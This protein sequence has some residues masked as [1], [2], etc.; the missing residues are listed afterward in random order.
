[1]KLLIFGGKGMAGHMLTQF[2][3][4][5]NNYDVNYTSRDK[6]DLESYYLDVRNFEKLVDIFK[7]LKPDIVINAVGLLN[8]QASQDKMT[9]IQ[10]NSLLPHQLDN[11]AKKNG[12]KII[13]ISTDCVFSGNCGDYKENDLPDGISDYAK[14]KALGEVFSDQHLTIRTSI[15]GPELKSNGIGLF[16]WFM[17][18]KGQIKGYKSVY[19]NG[20][21]TLE[22][23]KAIEQLIEQKITGLYHLGS[24]TK[25]SKYELLK[26]IQEV[27][28]KRD[29]TIKPDSE[30]VL[31]RTIQ[32][33]RDD[34]DYQVP[35]YEDMLI[36]LK[37]WMEQK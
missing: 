12:V 3:K 10:V 24:A 9:A 25:I 22:L 4:Q 36:Q 1:M 27:F 15:I 21:T 34:F 17:K 2:F 32:N 29:V 30:I 28:E 11:L 16:H 23:A 20:V 14:S 6:D 18:Q 31:D 26:L 7:T 13:H 37:D 8:E 33:T 5:K 19:W 35:S